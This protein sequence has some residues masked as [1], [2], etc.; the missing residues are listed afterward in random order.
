MAYNAI[1]SKDYYPG[2][3]YRAIWQSAP[4]NIATSS[5]R[6]G[7]GKEHY[8]CHPEQTGL[9]RDHRSG[10]FGDDWKTQA[11]PEAR[12]KPA[13]P[14][15]PVGSLFYFTFQLEDL[16]MDFIVYVALVRASHSMRGSR[17][18]E[19]GGKRYAYFKRRCTSSN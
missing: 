11:V 15:A 8:P 4:N 13:E 7:P 19:Q 2:S 10:T 16:I 6:T 17:Q 5:I 18:R 12:L 9:C 14:P 1:K 3:A